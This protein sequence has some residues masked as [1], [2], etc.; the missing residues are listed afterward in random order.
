[1]EIEQYIRRTFSVG[2]VQVTEANMHEVANWC[3]GRVQISKNPKTEQP[4]KHVKV[5]VQR[6]LNPSQSMAFVGNWVAFG[7]SG[8]KVFTDAAFKKIF[9]LDSTVVVLV[10]NNGKPEKTTVSKLMAEFKPAD[11]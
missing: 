10:D 11:E 9:E 3:G 8:Y 2:A 5:F 1:M 6:P 7:A 4:E